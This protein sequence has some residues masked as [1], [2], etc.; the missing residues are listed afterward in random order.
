M[1]VTGEVRDP[2]DHITNG[3]TTLRDAIY[4][5]GGV[6]PNALM[7]DA[8]V[9]R[10][11]SDG[12]MEVVSV[13]LAEA[14]AGDPAQNLVLQ[15]KDRLFVHKNLART[16]PPVVIIS[17]E[18]ARP[19]TYAL[20]ENMTAATLVKLAGGFKRGAYTQEADLRAMKSSKAASW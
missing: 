13:N 2:G 18:V 4:L 9:F 14:L 20:G 11:T 19:G 8:Q 6:T 16:D 1:T 5:A 12:K 17:G 15:S 10:R 3:S 7:D